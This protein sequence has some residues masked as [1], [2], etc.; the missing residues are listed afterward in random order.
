MPPP[1]WSPLWAFLVKKNVS[2]FDWKG[3]CLIKKLNVSIFSQCLL[4]Y[5]PYKNYHFAESMSL[6]ACSFYWTG[7]GV[8]TGQGRDLLVCVSPSFSQCLNYSPGNELARI[9]VRMRWAPYKVSKSE[10]CVKGK[11]RTAFCKVLLESS[12]RHR[13]NSQTK[14]EKKKKKEQMK[15]SSDCCV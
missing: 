11:D 13:L 6:S 8:P 3:K 15:E 7:L 14:L 9:Q 2:S 10:I 1:H 12:N 4:L 5:S